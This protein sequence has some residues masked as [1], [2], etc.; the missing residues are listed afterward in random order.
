MH[1]AVKQVSMAAVYGSR[2]SQSSRISAGLGSRG[3]AI[4]S[5][6]PGGDQQRQGRW[7]RV[8]EEKNR[9]KFPFFLRTLAAIIAL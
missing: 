5:G 7:G 6:I 1:R 8:P 3:A 9:A 2:R 4:E